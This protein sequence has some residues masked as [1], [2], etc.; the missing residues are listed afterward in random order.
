MRETATVRKS[1]VTR[2]S[3]P[4]THGEPLEGWSCRTAGATTNGIRSVTGFSQTKRDVST[5]QTSWR[6]AIP[7]QV[8]STS[9]TRATLKS[10]LNPSRGIFASSDQDWFRSADFRQGIEESPSLPTADGDIVIVSKRE[11]GEHR[12]ARTPQCIVGRPVAVGARRLPEVVESRTTLEAPLDR[13]KL[14]LS[15]KHPMSPG[16]QNRTL[17]RPT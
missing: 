12:P 10:T 14:T 8:T 6:Q 11:S 17:P 5:C 3:V 16:T 13:M 1:S 15:S 9:A 7:S 2:T 4:P